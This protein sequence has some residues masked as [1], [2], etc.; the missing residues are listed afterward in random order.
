VIIVVPVLMINCQ[1]S[2]KPNTGPLIPQTIRII[3]ATTNTQA[4]PIAKAIVDVKR[5]NISFGLLFI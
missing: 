1:V 2:E 4:W 3:K 5:V